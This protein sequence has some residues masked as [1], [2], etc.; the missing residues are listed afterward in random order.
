MHLPSGS[1]L[2]LPLVNY[3]ILN[4]E[5]S[6]LLLVNWAVSS[7]CILVSGNILWEPC[8]AF[9]PATTATLFMSPLNND[10]SY[11]IN[12]PIHYNTKS[13]PVHTF[14]NILM[15]YIQI[16]LSFY[17][18]LHLAVYLKYLSRYHLPRL[19]GHQLSSFVFSKSEHSVKPLVTSSISSSS[20]WT[21]WCTVQSSADCMGL[22][23][24]LLI[25]TTPQDNDFFFSHS[26]LDSTCLLHRTCL[27]QSSLFLISQLVTDIPDEVLGTDRRREWKWAG[28]RTVGTQTTYMWTSSALRTQWSPSSI[29]SLPFI[30]GMLLCIHTFI[31]C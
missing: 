22:F 27:L 4:V 2:I 8:M 9:V 17:L 18:S 28:E 7:G 23:S 15:G 6:S 20:Q 25:G 29:I 10:K 12:H 5:H 24:S 13:S 30:D 31:V 14:V 16:Y 26:H 11:R 3:F 1:W 21:A 19:S